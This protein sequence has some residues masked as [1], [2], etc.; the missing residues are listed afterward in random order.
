VDTEALREDL[1]NL[2]GFLLSST[3]GLYNEP[4]DYGIF[5]LIDATGRL[6]SIMEAHG[7]S[8]DFLKNLNQEITDEMAGSMD[9]D[10][11]KET[12]SRITLKYADELQR[13]L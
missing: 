5:R 9:S 13:R 11:Q 4:A 8:D 10:R 12:V 7:I 2:I 3:H 1:F 6:L